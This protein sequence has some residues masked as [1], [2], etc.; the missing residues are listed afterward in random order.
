MRGT[1]T[2]GDDGPPSGTV[3]V[4]PPVAVGGLAGPVGGVIA[5]PVLPVAVGLVALDVTKPWVTVGFLRLR[6]PPLGVAVLLHVVDF[7]V[8]LVRLAFADGL[9]DGS[10]RRTRACS[11]V[12]SST[13]SDTC[14]WSRAAE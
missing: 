12:A 1:D 4:A 6:A 14:S 2:E 13:S 10:T 8:T 3:V 11:S 7:A 9:F 5:A